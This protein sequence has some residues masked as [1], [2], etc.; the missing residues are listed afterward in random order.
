VPFGVLS[1]AAIA[2][3]MIC[4]SLVIKSP[5]FSMTDCKR[6][7][8]VI[9]RSKLKLWENIRSLYISGTCMGRSGMIK[10]ISLGVEHLETLSIT[11]TGITHHFGD[12]I[13]SQCWN[14]NSSNSMSNLTKIYIDNESKFGDRGCEKLIR[15]L[16][17][18][19]T[20][21]T[22]SVTYSNL[23]SRSIKTLNKLCTFSKS[24]KYLILS[25][26]HFK[27]DDFLSIIRV[28]AN[29]GSF[30][31]LS[32]I[33]MRFQVPELN[34]NEI[35]T[36]SQTTFKISKSIKVYSSLLSNPELYSKSVNIENEATAVKDLLYFD[37]IE[38]KRIN[39][40]I[41][42]TKYS[43]IDMFLTIASGNNCFTKSF[44]I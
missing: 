35:I 25:G 20:L 11:N 21:K 6:L 31:S 19:S 15:Y 17:H 34:E 30:G 40:V 43:D 41:E 32:S 16:Q 23:T 7:C 18:M 38:S 44:Y 37:E 22:F 27:K 9:E 29:K 3:L 39:N 14:L 12:L 28:I 8:G 10:I 36:I 24:L 4:S 42:N 13:G 33:N 5:S 1:D 26:N 2:R